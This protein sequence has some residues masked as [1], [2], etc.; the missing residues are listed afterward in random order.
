MASC[1]VLPH[2]VKLQWAMV[3]FWGEAK[4]PGLDIRWC[5]DHLGTFVTEFYMECIIFTRKCLLCVRVIMV[6]YACISIPNSDGSD[7]ST[8]V[9]AVG[10]AWA[11]T[12][13]SYLT[14]Q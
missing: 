4:P 2:P 9:Y 1:Q 8:Q 12:T 7:P 5:V 3:S 13:M 10:C 11:P 14:R 6:F